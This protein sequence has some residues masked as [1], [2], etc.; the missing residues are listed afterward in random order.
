MVK[1]TLQEWLANW[2]YKP[3]FWHGS[4]CSFIPA[5]GDKSVI[6][7]VPDSCLNEGHRMRAYDLV[8]YRVSSISGGSIYF[9]ARKFNLM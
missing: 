8:D 6:V 7:T 4:R 1:M 2:P 9:V 5:F 3:M